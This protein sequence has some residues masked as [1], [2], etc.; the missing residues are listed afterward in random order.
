VRIFLHFLTSPVESAAFGMLY[1]RMSCMSV[2]QAFVGTSPLMTIAADDLQAQ[3]RG[4]GQP[5]LD[6]TFT[7]SRLR[8]H[9]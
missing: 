1:R 3:Q 4:F 9:D 5:A 2:L 6:R 7:C 8:V